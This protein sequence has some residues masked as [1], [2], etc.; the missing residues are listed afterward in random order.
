MAKLT[1][2]IARIAL[3]DIVGRGLSF[4]TTI[5]L[6]RTLGTESF[7]LIIISLSFL[8]YANWFADLGLTHIAGRE[9]AK[10][11]LKRVF[12]AREIF[13]LKIFM[14]FSVLGIFSFLLPFFNIPEVQKDLILSFAF[15][16]IPFTFIL[17]WYYNGRQ[18]FGKIA[19]SKIL[20]SA[21]YLILV[22]IL[23]K[24]QED[25][26]KV[27]FL[28]ITGTAC[29]AL[30]FMFFSIKDKAFELPTRGWEIYSDLLKSA[31]RVG[32]GTF[33]TQLLQLL[34]PILIGF[35]LSAKYAGIYGASIRIIFIAMM[36]D[37][38][39]VHLLLPNLA[40]QWIENRTAAKINII[41]VSRILLLTA[42]SVSLFVAVA[43]PLVIEI[44][45]GTEYQE[46]SFVLTVLC[47]FLFFTFLN[48]L[49]AFGLIAIGKDQQ[50]FKST[51]VSGIISTLLIVGASV[52]QTF[53]YV[54]YAVSFSEIVF[55]GFALY[56]FNKHIK[57]NIVAP[58]LI[59]LIL[60]ITL[61]LLTFQ[62]QFPIIL[63]AILV[64]L[65][66]IPLLLISR[67]ANLNH[68]IWLKGKLS[69]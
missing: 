57:L 62:I 21:V 26:Q 59:T 55:M 29:S 3:G 52:T 37:R 18:H 50:F 13:Y 53:D 38:I 47:I 1:D 42:G 40:S 46:S 5:Y 36:I 35:F 28:F 15:A 43:S 8:G 2:K 56:W 49:F 67:V 25:L 16:L 54:V 60:G 24:S 45:Y 32:S 41:S 20:N 19:F 22:M 10:E 33:F 27:P 30:F 64:V 48:S 9:I 7:G 14:N 6:A 44:V 66:F 12:R 65:I 17:E 63:E 4:F 31:F 39:F 58:I 34:P 69:K 11:P 23:I 68:F 51:L 61:Y